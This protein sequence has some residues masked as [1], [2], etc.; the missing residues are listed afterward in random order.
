MQNSVGVA[1]VEIY[2]Y[3]YNLGL[4][5]WNLCKFNVEGVWRKTKFVLDS[6]MKE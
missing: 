4:S 5:F 2:I 1:S 3:M 6:F